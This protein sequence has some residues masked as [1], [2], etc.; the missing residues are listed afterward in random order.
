NTFASVSR[1]AKLRS[2][3]ELERPALA[4][5]VALDDPAFRAHFAGSPAKRIGHARF[6]RNVLIGIDNSD[7]PALADAALARLDDESPLIRGAAI[8]ALRRLDSTRAD[9]LQDNHLARETDPD[10]RAEWEGDV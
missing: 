9:A 3:P 1:E 2:R 4:D 6:I 8:W 10:V 5:L 7:D